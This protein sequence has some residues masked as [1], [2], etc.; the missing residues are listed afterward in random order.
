MLL[1]VTA[2][3]D[4]LVAVGTRGHVLLSDDGE[5]WRQVDTPV[6]AALTAVTS[7]GDEVWAVRVAARG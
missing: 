3:G 2:V 6:R 4:R 1:D 7:H 5:S